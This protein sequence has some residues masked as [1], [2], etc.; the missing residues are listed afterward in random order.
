MKLI[1]LAEID[2]AEIIVPFTNDE[3]SRLWEDSEPWQRAFTT[4]LGEISNNYPKIK[5]IWLIKRTNWIL[6]HNVWDIPITEAL[7]FYTQANKLGKAGYKSENLSKVEQSP[8]NSVQRSELFA[9][10]MVLRNF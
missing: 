2:P 7:T 3:N 1:Q 6:P 9:I 4:F 10:L 5:R 8:Y